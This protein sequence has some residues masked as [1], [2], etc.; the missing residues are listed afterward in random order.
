MNKKTE[1]TPF[2]CRRGGANYRIKMVMSLFNFE[3]A[4]GGKYR[5]YG[6]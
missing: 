6:N 5:E 1:N 2:W 3:S 4:P